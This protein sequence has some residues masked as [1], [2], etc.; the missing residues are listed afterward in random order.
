MCNSN[1]EKKFFENIQ[2]RMMLQIKRLFTLKKSERMLFYFALMQQEQRKLKPI[3]VI[4]AWCFA[5]LRQHKHNVILCHAISVQCNL[6]IVSRIIISADNFLN[7]S[8]ICLWDLFAHKDKTE[9]L[10]KGSV[11]IQF[12]YIALVQQYSINWNFIL[13]FCQ[14]TIHNNIYRQ[15]TNRMDM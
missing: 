3:Y 13:S 8:W 10:S 5:L 4:S 14:N 9:E 11:T 7:F 2:I 15:W 12:E 6:I 1:R